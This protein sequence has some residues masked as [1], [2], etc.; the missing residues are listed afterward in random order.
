[1]ARTATKTLNNGGFAALNPCGKG[2]VVDIW[3]HEQEM[4]RAE[5]RITPEPV[6]HAYHQDLED[7]VN[8]FEAWEPWPAN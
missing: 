2:W 3:S 6:Y 1:M 7:A 5:T 8:D 4:E